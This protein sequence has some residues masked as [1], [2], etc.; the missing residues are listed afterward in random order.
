MFC[1]KTIN[2]L[3]YFEKGKIMI[4]SDK[5]KKE[6]FKNV[7]F[8]TGTA[9]GGKT[10]I[11]KAL[12][13]KYGWLR[14]DVDEEFDRHK[15]LSNSKDNPAMNKTFKNADEFFMRDVNEYEKWL[16]DNTLSLIHI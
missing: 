9:T 15:S 3:F 7:Y 16:K 13:E 6:Q 5:Y 12:A 10:T 11:S 1:L 8:I 14:Y 2:G 4:Y